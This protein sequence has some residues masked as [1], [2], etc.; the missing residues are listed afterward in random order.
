MYYRTNATFIG[1]KK[2]KLNIIYSALLLLLS[3]ITQYYKKKNNK[4]L[5]KRQ[6]QIIKNKPIKQSKRKNIYNDEKN[7]FF[8]ND[9]YENE[10]SN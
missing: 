6:S 1:Q 9:V 4:K 8:Y 2:I 3:G 10:C 7:I 5:L